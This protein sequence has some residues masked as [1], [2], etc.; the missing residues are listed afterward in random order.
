MAVV[1]ISATRFS[2]G[3]AI[4]EQTAG[5]LGCRLVGREVLGV[6]ASRYGVAEDLLA[7]AV[8]GR[9]SW[10]AMPAKD[11]RIC[12]AFIHAA[13]SDLLLAGDCVCHRLASHLYVTGISHVVKVRIAAP[14]EMR[15]GAAA[16]VRDISDSKAKSLVSRLDA[17]RRRWVSDLYGVDE[18]DP[19]NFDLMIDRATTTIEQAASEIAQTAVDSR[20]TPM[21]YSLKQVRDQAL[22]SKVRAAL[23]KVDPE[24]KV[25]ADDG[26]I[27]IEATDRGR[28]S[29]KAATFEERARAVPNVEN[30]EITMVEDV[31]TKAAV[32][33]R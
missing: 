7:Q 33:M 31:F 19:A 2:G 23:V 30:V 1:I 8:D 10:R 4:A 24:V 20:F 16:R 15:I 14:L 22:A 32:S 6:A 27:H 26:A 12:L 17:R 18:D 21:S 29:R 5:L 13:L 11:R 3:G 9:A 28:G 25:R